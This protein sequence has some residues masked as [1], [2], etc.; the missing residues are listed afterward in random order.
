[1]VIDAWS[2]GFKKSK[3][4][5]KQEKLAAMQ[6]MKYASGYWL[7]GFSAA[8]GTHMFVGPLIWTIVLGSEIVIF[9]EKHI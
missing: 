5:T 1:M 9:R 3:S 2:I 7:E 8:V 4:F 6:I